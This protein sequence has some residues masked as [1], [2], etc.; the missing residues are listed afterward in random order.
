MKL[1]EFFK[2]LI[3]TALVISSVVLASKIWFSEELWSDG[4]N[5]FSY[6]SF[7]FSKISSLFRKEPKVR[8][9]EYNQIF[10]PKQ[11]M[12]TN[13]GVAYL[14]NPTDEEYVPVNEDIKQ[15]LDRMFE[16]FNVT[17]I[18][19]DEF[20][21]LCKAP[22]VFV[23][24]YNNTSFKML[25][26]YFGA[27]DRAEFSEIINIRQLLITP[28]EPAIYARNNQSGKI[29]RCSFNGDMEKLL[30]ITD[31]VSENSQRL[32]SYAFENG[33]DLLPE[34]SNGPKRMLLDPYII[35]NIGET[36]IPETE[37]VMLI[38]EKDSETHAKFLEMF[39]MGI[40]TSRYFSEK[41]GTANYIE[42][43]AKLRINKFGYLEYTSMDELKGLELGEGISSEYDIIKSAGEFLEQV[44]GV[45]PLPEGNGYVFN[46]L[47]KD[48]DKY[49]VYFDITYNGIPVIVGS[50][51]NVEITVDGTK[52]VSYKQSVIAFKDNGKK[53]KVK[54]M[55]TAL[56]AFYSVYGT[57]ASGDVKITDMYNTYYY[58]GNNKNIGV[59]WIVSLSN[60]EQVVV[61]GK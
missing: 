29:Y 46:R 13:S 11:L 17:E 18:G 34:D 30:K 23:D 28:E 5:S 45:C 32:Y 33:F 10:F 43:Y 51:S 38:K 40:N 60:N 59:K 1:R 55:I 42:N 14:L 19:N 48:G 57:K 54:N 58:N 26:D 20:K 9:L 8:S 12:I 41:D 15:V 22:S 3:L 49:R 4:Y 37:A 6:N 7:I 61:E 24:F 36:D 39:N 27:E 56:D 21:K 25:G 16:D 44:N 53:L 52:I 31:S 50:Q 2:T 35:I 47:E